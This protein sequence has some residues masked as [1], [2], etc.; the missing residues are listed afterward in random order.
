MKKIFIVLLITT[1]LYADIKTMD[2]IN[3]VVNNSYKYIREPTDKWLDYNTFKRVGGGDCEDFVI[4]KY[5][6]ATE[7]FN[8]RK[9]DFSFL[10]VTPTDKHIILLYKGKEYDIK[11][12]ISNYKVLYKMDAKSFEYLYNK[13]IKE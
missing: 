6:I 3:R 2:T 12:P 10:V 7:M 1:Y 4:A 13:K 8:L 11:N 5:I 9:Q